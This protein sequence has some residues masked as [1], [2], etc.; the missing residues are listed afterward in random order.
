M[1]N[2]RRLYIPGGTY[3]FTV[4]TYHRQPIFVNDARVELLRYAFREVK[5]KRPFD[6]VAVVILPNHLHCLWNLPDGDADFSTHW[7]MIKT[8]FSRRIPASIRKDGSKTVWQLP[9]HHFNVS[10]FYS[11]LKF[12]SISP[13]T[14]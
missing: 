6:I 3:F 8:G 13:I 10:Y 14:R 9:Y 2:Y 7:Q 1:S 11:F 4:V 5:A 12:N